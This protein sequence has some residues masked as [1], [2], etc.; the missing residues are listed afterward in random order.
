MEKELRQN[1][2]DTLKTVSAKLPNIHRAIQNEA[3]YK[4]VEEQMIKTM[5]NSEMT[6]SESLYH[7]EQML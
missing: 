7:V 3:G 2:A 4:R 1:I 6:A 5:I